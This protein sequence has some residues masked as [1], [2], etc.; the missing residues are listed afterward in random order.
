MQTLY[1]FS[2]YV[3]LV[4]EFPMQYSKRKSYRV[5]A[6]NNEHFLIVDDG[7]CFM[8]INM[9]DCHFAWINE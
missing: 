6:V 9:N 5:L 8:W 4:D 1:K 2:V 7:G 3:D